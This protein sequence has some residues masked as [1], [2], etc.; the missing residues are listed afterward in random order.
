[1]Y[2]METLVTEGERLVLLVC[3]EGLGIKNFKIFHETKD[4]VD[5]G[6]TLEPVETE[7][8]ITFIPNSY[9]R[10]WVTQTY[11]LLDLDKKKIYFSTHLYMYPWQWDTTS[12]ST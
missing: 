1:M 4:C 8:L 3:E 5:V 12:A 2:R 10:L 6:Y 7:T 11:Y 9:K